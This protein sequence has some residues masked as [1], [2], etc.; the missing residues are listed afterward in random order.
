MIFNVIKIFGCK[1]K[2]PSLKLLDDVLFKLDKTTSEDPVLL[3]EILS[4]WKPKISERERYGIPKKLLKDG[5]IENI[6]VPTNNRKEILRGL[7]C[8]F[9]TY[10]GL[11]LLEQDNGYTGKKQRE[12]RKENLDVIVKKL[13]F[14]S[15]L[16]SLLSVCISGGALYVNYLIYLDR[17]AEYLRNVV[18]KNDPIENPLHANTQ[19]K[20]QDK[21]YKDTIPTIRPAQT[22]SQTKQSSK[23]KR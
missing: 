3:D 4:D 18:E 15:I 11:I 12:D 23:E 20:P 17:K 13:V 9:I 22:K 5:M 8:Q 21:V 16:V 1:E 14:V 7:T 6:S 10:E 2:Y 19:I